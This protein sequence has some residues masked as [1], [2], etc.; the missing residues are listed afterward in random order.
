MQLST[1]EGR[2]HHYAL[3][4]TT[5]MHNGFWMSQRKR[6]GLKLGQCHVHMYTL[7]LRWLPC[8]VGASVYLMVPVGEG[9]GL[10]RWAMVSGM[11]MVSGEMWACTGFTGDSGASCFSLFSLDRA[12]NV[13]L[14]FV[15]GNL[16]VHLKK[17]SQLST[18]DCQAAGPTAGDRAHVSPN[19]LEPRLVL[20]S[21]R[22]AHFNLISSVTSCLTCD[23]TKEMSSHELKTLVSKNLI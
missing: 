21:Q 9:R 12:V 7:T 17:K 2:H 4:P 5:V 23:T 6:Q 1:W 20:K 11:L 10:M 14:M 22:E 13:I 19:I 3:L 8:P 18:P 15:L 16:N